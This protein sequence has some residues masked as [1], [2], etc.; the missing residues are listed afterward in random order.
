VS[1]TV[2]QGII[3]V[4]R[5]RLY[6][7]TTVLAL[8]CALIAVSL[9][10]RL[11]FGPIVD[12]VRRDPQP[13]LFA[14]ESIWEFCKSWLPQTGAISQTPA[15]NAGPGEYVKGIYV[16]HYA[17]GSD[18]IMG[19]VKEL[20]ENTELNAVVMDV[21]GDRGFIVYPTQV[22][23]AKQIGAD[24]SV[25]VKD[26]P[27]FM[28]WFKD[29]KIRT[30]ARVVTFKDN[31]LSAA[32]PEW[33]VRD[34]ATGRPWKDAEGL[35]WGDPNRPEVQDYNIALAVE[36]AKL[37]FDEVQF[38]YVRFPSDGAVGRA[39]F[40]GTN[41]AAT[42]VSTIARFLGRARQALAPY[43][44]KVSADTFG[45]TAW[46]T[47]DMGI[48][49]LVEDIAPNLDVLSPMLYPSTFA[50]GLPSDGG[51]YRKAVAFPYEILHKSTQRVLARAKSVNPRLEIR[52]WIQDFQ[53]YAFDERI[54]TPDEIRA[55]MDGAREA[56][57]RGW[58]LWNAGVNYTRAALVSAQPSYPPNVEGF[59]PVLR[60]GDIN[61]AGQSGQRTPDD[62]RADLG[63]L[64]AAGYYPVT[65]R[66]MVEERLN[67]VPEGKR[68]V[69]LTFDGAT[70]GQFRLRPDGSVDP[71][72][73]VGIL[74][75]FHEAHPADWPLRATFFVAP[76]GAVPDAAIF[77][78]AESAQRKLEMLRKWGLEVGS[79]GMGGGKLAGKSPAEVQRELGLSQ[80]LLE[81]W[82]PGR[83]IVS[84]ALPDGVFPTDS[85]LA[86][87]GEHEGVAY[88]Y[89]AIA[90]GM[91]GMA[92]APSSPRF[93]P[94]R[95]PR[96]DVTGDALDRWLKIA[97][98]PGV[99]YVSAGE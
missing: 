14:S 60:Y 56:G 7:L 12:A 97:E 19:R 76:G 78:Q 72:S 96:I 27:E 74:Q 3:F 51:A 65:L 23:L 34:S 8:I 15:A 80:T 68:P 83:R 85:V 79:Y 88:A 29:R 41:T 53:D 71:D 81:R 59:V 98:R 95:I 46:M 82:L 61:K 25:T 54:Y 84:L 2:F 1:P 69:V 45:Y 31:L 13:C 63:R 91:A 58:L 16:S 92:P 75:A 50:D 70:P 6:L 35:G 73:A 89:G 55:Q 44:V 52:P 47:N 33:A 48:G 36:A 10:T 49:Q 5:W 86:A 67:M 66:Q 39:T 77:G 94:L 32:H 17:A 20:L 30:I 64:L 42:R 43:N 11:G 18:E 24:G 22:A 57:G 62:F 9:A 26:L 87:N 38:D 40:S 4:K 99:S 28:R 90:G 21:K 93:D 37:G